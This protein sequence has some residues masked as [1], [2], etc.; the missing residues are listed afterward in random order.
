MCSAKF[1]LSILFLFAANSWAQQVVGPAQILRAEVEKPKEEESEKWWSV[2]AYFEARQTES[3]MK[4]AEPQ[5]RTEIQETE[6]EINMRPEK[7]VN[8]KISVGAE[9]FDNE[10]QFTL[11]EVYIDFEP[12]PR[13]FTLRAGQ[14]LV[15]L[16]C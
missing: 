14:M 12:L 13:W 6:L 15:P 7:S 5:S 8:F 1:V 16:F 2:R 3:H 10:S 11:R 9:Q 4:R